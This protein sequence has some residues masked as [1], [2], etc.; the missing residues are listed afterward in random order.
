MKKIILSVLMS[1]L[2][3]IVSIFIM[4]VISEIFHLQSSPSDLYFT[5]ENQFSQF[6]DTSCFSIGFLCG[7]FIGLRNDK[8]YWPPILYYLVVIF[9]SSCWLYLLAYS[10]P[11]D[12]YGEP[13]CGGYHGLPWG[14]LI[15]SYGIG[16]LILM[17]K[18]RK[19]LQ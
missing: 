2:G 19:Q 16:F 18:L 15:G 13:S 1:V 12:N 3:T 9:I 11:N 7:G 8:R 17:I 6:L 4:R 14:G 5:L 10:C